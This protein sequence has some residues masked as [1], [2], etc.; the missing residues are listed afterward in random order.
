MKF[1]VLV[2]GGA[3][4][5][6]PIEG[7]E[8]V[9][10]DTCVKRR[11]DIVNRDEYIDQQIIRMNG[12]RAH[13]WGPRDTANGLS[14]ADRK[15]VETQS[16]VKAQDYM[17]EG[18]NALLIIYF[19]QPSN[20]G[21]DVDDY[22]TAES[23]MEE[24]VKSQVKLLLEMRQKNMKYLVGYG[25]GFPHKQGVSGDATNYIVNKTCNYYTKQHEED[26]QTYGEI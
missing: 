2:M 4:E 3:A 10:T 6:T 11:F 22:F 14:E 26:Y 17:I 7:F 15:R 21:V 20:E 18:R 9:F 13:L 25:I 12:V 5:N 1:D 24:E 23:T 16:S 19:I 8:P